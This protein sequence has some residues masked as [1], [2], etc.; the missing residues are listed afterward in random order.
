[1]TKFEKN[2]QDWEENEEIGP[3]GRIFKQ[4]VG[5]SKE[6]IE[7]L[8]QEQ[9]GEALGALIHPEI[10]AID[11]IWGEAG[12][13]KSDG[14]GLSKIVKYHPEVVD[15]LQ[16]IIS[17]MI[18]VK[19]ISENRLHLKSERYRAV[20]RLTWDN[21]RK[22]WLLTAFEKKN[23]VLDNTTDTGETLMGERNDKATPQDTVSETKGN[24]KT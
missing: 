7:R 5:K 2:N 6:A 14:Y 20:V 1:M 3:F 9:G 13:Q 10:G 23:S 17:D 12:T 18:V 8:I 22:T 15:N 19:P 24:E 16:E 11:L 4:Y 21:Q